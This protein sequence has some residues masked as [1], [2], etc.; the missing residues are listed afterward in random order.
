MFLGQFFKATP[1]F[2]NLETLTV[3]LRDQMFFEI[4]MAM[5]KVREL[6]MSMLFSEYSWSLRLAISVSKLVKFGF[7]L[8]N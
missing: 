1:N 8:K 4:Y 3:I 7:A 6:I 2:D 5:V